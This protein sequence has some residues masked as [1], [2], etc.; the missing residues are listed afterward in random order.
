[1]SGQ[2]LLEQTLHL[3]KEALYDAERSPL[4]ILERLTHRALV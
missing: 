4:R 2:H 3:P 1:M